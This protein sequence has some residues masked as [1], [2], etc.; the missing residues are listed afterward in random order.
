MTALRL[1]SRS[2]QMKALLRPTADELSREEWLAQQIAAFDG[3]VPQAEA[4]RWKKHPLLTVAVLAQREDW[5]EQVLSWGISLELIDNL[6]RTA[7][8]YAVQCESTGI[9]QRLIDAGANL[10]AQDGNHNTPLHIAAQTN[11]ENHVA[12]LVDHGANME[13]VTLLDTTTP[14][15]D[16]A[17]MSLES[18]QVLL[19]KGAN[20]HAESKH[21][22]T[23][24]IAAIAGGNPKAVPVLIAA[25]ADVNHVDA[26]GCPVLWHALQRTEDLRNPDHNSFGLLL[27]A[28][29]DPCRELPEG[30]TLMHVAAQHGRLDHLTTLI[31][32]AVPAMVADE[33]GITPLDILNADHPHLAEKFRQ[34][35]LEQELPAPAPRRTGPRF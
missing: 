17:R 2:D 18:A 28:H 3:D 7:L 29:A 20:V 32:M 30:R 15:I 14:L 4:L 21:G 31:S 25:G 5:V 23:P 33:K 1:N 11:W 35:V 9:V 26:Q 34:R 6:H 19:E 24:L 8:H 22:E 10:Q 12:L 16:A 27:A 13:A